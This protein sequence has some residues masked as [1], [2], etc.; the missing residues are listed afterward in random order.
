MIWYNIICGYIYIYIYIYTHTY[1]H[2]HVF[3]YPISLYIHIHI[4]T[5]VY[6]YIYIYIYTPYIIPCY[7][8]SYT[9][10]TYSIVLNLR[11]LSG[12][13]EVPGLVQLS[14]VLRNGQSLWRYYRNR[15]PRENH[16]K[17][18]PKVFAPLPA[19]KHETMWVFVVWT[20]LEFPLFYWNP[21][22][23]AKRIKHLTARQCMRWVLV[24]PRHKRWDADDAHV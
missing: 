22:L 1:T 24:N 15:C 3:I 5:Y 2:M 12:T 9:I 8:I 21:T 11:D 16:T 18:N 20:S 7:I 14:K 13:R 19:H 6:V 4:Y 23:Q 10:T 17:D